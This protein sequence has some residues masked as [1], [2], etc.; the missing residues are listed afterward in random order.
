[1]RRKNEA[2]MLAGQYY[3]PSGVGV[4]SIERLVH[5]GQVRDE[6]VR[7]VEGR[8]LQSV[9]HSVHSCSEFL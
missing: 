1:M 2:R 4:P 3:V 7:I 8:I 5:A 9:K 6:S